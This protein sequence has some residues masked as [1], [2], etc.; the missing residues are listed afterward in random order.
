MRKWAFLIALLVAGLA[1]SGY[2]YFK[3]QKLQTSINNRFKHELSSV[4][5]NLSLTMN[6]DTYR[7]VLS[8]VSNAAS[9]SD[10]TSYEEQNDSLDISLEYLYISLREDKS[11]DKVLSRADELRDIFLVLMTDPASKEATDKILKITEETFLRNG[12]E[13]MKLRC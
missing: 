10:L 2:S 7:S 5:S 8:S 6:D 12:W 4:L 9:I 13:G 1:I 11:K 3:A